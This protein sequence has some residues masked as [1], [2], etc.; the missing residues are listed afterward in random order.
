[1]QLRVIIVAAIIKNYVAITGKRISETQF[2]SSSMSGF[3]FVPAGK[4]AGAFCAAHLMDLPIC[5]HVTQE[6][7]H[8]I[9]RE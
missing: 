4:P 6:A 8:L 3:Y 7:L 1:M 5:L 9:M 2:D